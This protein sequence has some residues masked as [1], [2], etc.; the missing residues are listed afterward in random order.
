MRVG[1]AMAIFQRADKD[2]DRRLTQ[3]E[4]VEA[5]TPPAA[6]MARMKAEMPPAKA[7]AAAAQVRTKASARFERLDANHDGVLTLEEITPS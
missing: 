4:Y 3:V 6:V 2:L 5:A 7:D 1:S